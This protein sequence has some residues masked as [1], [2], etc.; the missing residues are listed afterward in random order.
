MRCTSTLL[1]GNY[2]WHHQGFCVSCAFTC[3]PLCK[4]LTFCLVV[5]SFFLQLSLL[6]LS[7]AAYSPSMVAAA[8]LSNAFELFNKESWPQMLQQYSAYKTKEVQSCKDRLKEV[9]AT[10]SADHLRRIWCSQH[11]NHGYDEFNEAW[12]KAQLT[13]ACP[14]QI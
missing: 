1:P 7:C 11:E 13:L 14:T 12:A 8:S 6:D 2:V 10:T 5:C 9:Q 4:T 3:A